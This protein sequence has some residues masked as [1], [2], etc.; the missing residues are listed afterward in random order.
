ML[1]GVDIEA[2]S[3][4]CPAAAASFAHQNKW[5]PDEGVL[6]IDEFWDSYAF[7]FNPPLVE[8][9]LLA[10]R[11]EQS[12]R[13]LNELSSPTGLIR[14]KGDSL[15][16]VLAFLA[17]S[18][19]T[20]EGEQRE[21]LR[22]RT[23]IVQSESSARQ[24]ATMPNLI[25]AVRGQGAKMAGALGSDHPVIVPLGRESIQHANSIALTRPTTYEM[26]E[27][28]QQVG[29]S[30]D[31]AMRLAHECGR[32]V[33][34]L[35]R[36]IPS[37]DTEVPEWRNDQVLVSALMAGAWDRS[38]QA[39]MDALSAL[40][41]S[42]SYDALEASLRPYLALPDAPLETLGEIW[43]V[44][45]PVDLFVH[46]SHLFGNEHW[47][48][49]RKTV[50]KV[51]SERDPAW[52]M[53][54]D[55]RMYA[56]LHGKVLQHSSWLRDGIATTL[57]MLAALSKDG[58]R[59]IDGGTAQTFV[60]ELVAS[61]P[62]LR[63][64]WR[65]I[66]SLNQQLPLLMEAAPV[67]LLEALKHLL[68]GDASKMRPIFQD[69]KNGNWLFTSSPHTGLLWALEVAGQDPEFLQGAASVLAKL[70]GIDPGGRLSNRPLNS[71]R[72][73]FLT[74]KPVTNASHVF[75][76]A[77]LRVVVKDHPEVGW[78]LLL[79]LMPRGHD[80]GFDA[81]TPHFR[82][83]AASE[84]EPLTW[85]IVEET[86][87][88]IIQLAIG[89]AG[90]DPGRWI[91]LLSDLSALSASNREATIDA[92]RDAVGRMDSDECLQTWDPLAALIRRQ[93]T[94]PGSDWALP[95][96]VL[97]QLEALE[98]KVRPGS[99]LPRDRYLFQEQFPDIPGVE[100]DRLLER[101]EEVRNE[102]VKR[103]LTQEGINQVLQFARE[104]DAPRFVGKAF[105]NATDDPEV[106][107]RA[108][109]AKLRS[110]EPDRGFSAAASS[111]AQGR[112]GGRWRTL[113]Q[114]EYRNCELTIDQIQNLTQWWPHT[115]ETW[116]WVETL[117][118]DLQDVYWRNQRAWGIQATGQDFTYAVENYIGVDRPEFV[119]D[120]LYSRATEISSSD[121]I[122]IL[123]S[124][125]RR[126]S[127]FPGA[128]D[129]SAL[130]YKMQ[131]LFRALRERADVPLAKTAALEYRFLPL[132]RET[133]S[134]HDADSAL[135]QVLSESPEF[136]VQ[137]VSDV[138]RP[139]GER[140]NLAIAASP[141]AQARARTS[142]SLLESFARI[143]G[144]SG[145]DF[146]F[147]KLDSWVSEVQHL[148]EAADRREISEQY[149]GKLLSHVPPDPEDK[150]WPH[151]AIREGMEKWRS[152]QIELGLRMGK[153]NS[154]GV[155]SRAPYDGGQ[156]ERTLRDRYR[157]DAAKVDAWPRTKRVLL[158]LAERWEAMA[159]FEDSK[160]LMFPSG[161]RGNI[162]RCFG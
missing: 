16:E 139:R 71:L 144:Q 110:D 95:P 105:A 22:A 159:Q 66:A 89:L 117:G 13:L 135:D 132:L 88:A 151:R 36:R 78:E 103:L 14:C 39:D 90:T 51:L 5:F 53:P 64:D 160:R 99:S 29:L 61:L 141:D 133:W 130:G 23:L 85:A 149:I 52:D 82:D 35:A 24:L 33:S 40:A 47:A 41:G 34:I 138:F 124:F 8:S 48:R 28:L 115:R 119:L 20:A 56:R 91:A 45:A 123:E 76:V 111:V 154:R 74:W 50:T 19:R 58:N 96:D 67:P 94:Y 62:G 15:D 142:I 75:R 63:D 26:S 9:V 1:D 73:L 87:S 84:R 83:A 57:L 30:E 77:V 7:R 118:P 137:V 98:S 60:N 65:V 49:L 18:I 81:P 108:V 46:I 114:S 42:T 92:F 112:F 140:G 153:V 113:L 12:K 152:D 127:E 162:V 68:E 128:L 156:Q 25:F 155:T 86:V 147:N 102:V 93:K 70:H 37:G 134:E 4:L 6:S 109:K 150:V 146:D 55:E 54:Q 10:G 106:V 122:A 2:W 59:S 129:R 38:S 32:S 17:A 107:L 158:A 145:Q 100:P 157:T 72:A 136:F 120:A 43:A 143:P 131:F 11:A 79:K 161:G 148:A 125:E 101:T 80:I 126:A 3:E 27:A 69:S 21:F 97:S 116:D 44:R 31:R 104:V 121:L